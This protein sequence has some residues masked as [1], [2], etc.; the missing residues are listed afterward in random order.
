MLPV[1]LRRELLQDSGQAYTPAP[2]Q[3]LF[4]PSPPPEAL[5]LPTQRVHQLSV[6]RL[7]LPNPNQVR[8]AFSCS[9][10]TPFHLP[11]R[12]I[13]RLRISAPPLRHGWCGQ[14]HR[15]FYCG[16]TFGFSSGWPRMASI[17]STWRWDLRP[18]R[19]RSS[20]NAL[21]TGSSA[22]ITRIICDTSAII[23]QRVPL[24]SSSTR[25]SSGFRSRSIVSRSLMAQSLRPSRRYQDRLDRLWL[26]Q[27]ISYSLYL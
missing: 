24:A 7:L 6:G 20:R 4:V 18:Q 8:L 9:K 27:R 10:V 22:R 11:A 17:S 5:G 3:S 23:R 25:F 15:L 14:R 19:F 21:T 16:G 1:G 2:R 13:F 12:A 26:Q